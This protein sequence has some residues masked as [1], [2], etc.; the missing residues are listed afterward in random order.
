MAEYIGGK[1]P[2]EKIVQNLDQFFKQGNKHLRNLD[3]GGFKVYFDRDVMKLNESRI[4]LE[5][6]YVDR[7]NDNITTKVDPTNIFSHTFTF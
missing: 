3:N 6:T 1:D 2:T 5:D 4:V 7:L